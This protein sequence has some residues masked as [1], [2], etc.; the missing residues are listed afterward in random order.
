MLTKSFVKQIIIRNFG[1][2]QNRA[3]CPA[4]FCC[5]NGIILI[6]T[7]LKISDANIAT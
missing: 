1:K 4:L 6:V 3:S 7:C 5:H 2:Q